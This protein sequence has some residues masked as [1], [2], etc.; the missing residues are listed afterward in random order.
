MATAT[1]A[2]DG[3]KYSNNQR[4]QDESLQ[5]EIQHCGIHAGSTRHAILRNKTGGAV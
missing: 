1:G 5:P 4:R 3:D 2:S